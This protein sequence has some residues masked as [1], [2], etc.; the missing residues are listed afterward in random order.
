[1]TTDDLAN[2]QVEVRAPVCVGYRAYKVCGMAPPSS[3]GIGVGAILKQIEPFDIAGLGKDSPQAWHLI[4]ESM[5]L[6]YADR[7]QWIGDTAFVNVPV[8]GLSSDA[9]LK[10]RSALISAT[11]TIPHVTYGTPAGAP[12]LASVPDMEVAGTSSFAIAD[13]FGNVA[14]MTS[15]VESVFGSGLMVDGYVLNNELTDFNFVP[16]DE[17][18]APA[19]NRVEGGKRPRST[20]SPTIVLDAKGRVVA[21]IGAA[22]GPTIMA[23]VAKALIGVLDWKLPVQDAIA[24]PQIMASGDAIRVEQNSALEAMIPELRKAGQSV[25]ASG[26]PLKANGLE[27]VGS[28]WRGGA[29]VRSEGVSLGLK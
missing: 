21:A 23:Q 19:A 2:Y 27:R 15:T 16:T 17:S 6:A 10:S 28:G 25:T 3:G 7:A 20:M 24:L 12:K 14:A 11:E 1:M 5:R 22:G 4:G 8:E 18:G 29:D 9:Y 13:R 26:L